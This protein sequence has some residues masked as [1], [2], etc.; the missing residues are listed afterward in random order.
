MPAPR[1]IDFATL[2]SLIKER[3]KFTFMG[4][5]FILGPI[6]LLI[7]M[8][9]V[10]PTTQRP[11]EKYDYEEIA[12]GGTPATARITDI[13]LVNNINV[14][15]QSPR[16]ITY[17][18]TSNG[19]PR[20]DQFETFDTERA[21]TLRPNDTLAIK[22]LAGESVIPSLKP[23]SFPR[24]ALLASIPSLFALIGL[25]FLLIGALPTL[26]KYRLYRY[27]LAHTGTVQGIT[28]QPIRTF[29]GGSTP[30]YVISYHYAGSVNSQLFGESSTSDLLFVQEK[31]FGDLVDIFVSATDET[32]S[33]LVPRLAALKNNWQL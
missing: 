6:L 32:K 28:A 14:N 26:R 27:G 33:C 15:G 13:S 8:L 18:Y 22:V 10:M 1:P 30:S 16:L 17:Q 5:A 21:S 20:T 25:P 3:G 7:P 24:I 29:L 2:W 31:K 23:Y 11:S 4:L 12:R 9:F 19:Q